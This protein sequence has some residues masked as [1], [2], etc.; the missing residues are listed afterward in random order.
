MDIDILAVRIKNAR[1]LR[2]VTMEELAAAIDMN[3]STV[4]RYE[5]A[6]IK[7]PKRPVVQAIASYLNVN[8][9]W[10]TGESE[11]IEPVDGDEEITRY[12]TLLETRPD[13]RSLLKTAEGAKTEQVQAVVDFLTAL[14]SGAHD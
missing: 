11:S 8:M 13:L 1:K 6:R 5:A 4:Q 14:R 12:L 2:G 9:G 7:T 10:L 3:K